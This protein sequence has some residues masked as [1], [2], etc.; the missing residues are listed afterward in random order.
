MT[1]TV[2]IPTNIR[3]ATV[4]I[5]RFSSETWDESQRYL[6]RGDC[7]RA[8]IKCIYGVPQPLTTIAFKDTMTVIEMNNTTNQ[9]MGLGIIENM[10]YYD[11][12]YNIHANG[13]YNRFVYKGRFHVSRSQLIEHGGPDA[14]KLVETTEQLLFKGKTN[15]KRGIGV[16]RISDNRLP[17]EMKAKYCKLVVAILT[18]TA[19]ST[20]TSPS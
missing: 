19:T 17:Y 3:P 14:L 18:T 13:N 5:K 15:L 10:S 16:T 2:T 11:K 7:L 1:T 9:I 12:T 6:Q 4:G 8:G 20:T